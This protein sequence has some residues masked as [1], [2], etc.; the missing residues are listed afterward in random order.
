MKLVFVG[1]K[2]S[3]PITEE[4]ELAILCDNWIENENG[5]TEFWLNGDPIALIYFQVNYILPF[6][7]I[8]IN[9]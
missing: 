7:L 9:K 8:N 3:S 6:S 5:S 1:I 4:K 2:V